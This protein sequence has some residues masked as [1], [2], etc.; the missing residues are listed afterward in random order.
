ML[1]FFQER[2]IY[3]TKDAFGNIFVMDFWHFRN[4][5]F[6]SDYEQSSMDIRK[7]HILTHEYT[8]A[9]MLV[10]AFINP[11]HATILGL[12]GG[13]LLRSLSHTSPNC[14]LHAVELRQKVY[15]VASAFFGIPTSNTTIV[16]SDANQYLFEM[17]NCSTDIIF[18]DMYQSIQMNPFQRQE[19]FIHQCHRILSKKGWLVINYHQLPGLETDFFRMLF[20]CFSDIFVCQTSNKKNTILLASKK[21]LH[22]PLRYFELAVDILE[23]K[24]EVKISPLFKRLTQLHPNRT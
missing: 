21:K 13:C 9:M 17:E 22:F 4:L 12:G 3:R 19:M 5:T 10:L 16:I 11:S 20:N 24:L 2:I 14:Q 18:A 1:N 8:R 23:K 6:D 15:D 7:G